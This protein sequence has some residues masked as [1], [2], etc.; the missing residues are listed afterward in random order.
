MFKAADLSK[1]VSPVSMALTKSTA[2]NYN[3]YLYT[4]NLGKWKDGQKKSGFLSN[5]PFDK[6]VQL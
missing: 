1:S 4:L 5:L 3:R 6:L 2:S